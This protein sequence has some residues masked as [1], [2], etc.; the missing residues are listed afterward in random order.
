[1][2]KSIVLLLLAG[3]LQCAKAQVLS[4]SFSGNIKGS[5]KSSPATQVDPNL[6]PSLL[7]RG[8]AL[9][10]Q[11]ATYSFAS[12]FPV[13]ATKK[14]AVK[15]GAYY[16]FTIQ[17]KKDYAVSLSALDVVL[18]IQKNAPKYYRWQ[19]SLDGKN[20]TDL[21]N[22][23]IK[24][25]TTINNGQE[26]PTLDLSGYKALQHVPASVSITFRLYAWGGLGTTDNG[27]R[28]GKSNTQRSALV[29]KGKVTR[30]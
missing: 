25:G 18:R 14:D 30:Q 20:F 24:S 2:K 8:P 28:I 9:I 26:Q 23:D 5:E 1:M 4:W 13:N 6:E 27:F 3:T 10:P 16:Q 21:G 19:Y 7:T 12:A 17:A 15:A 29:L 22:A 11:K